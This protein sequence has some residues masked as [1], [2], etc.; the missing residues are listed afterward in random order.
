MPWPTLP[1]TVNSGS[2]SP[3]TILGCST[4][5]VGAGG[6]EGEGGAGGEAGGGLGEG[7]LMVK[8]E[9]WARRFKS[10]GRLER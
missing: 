2:N 1:S 3:A 7:N 6:R 8:L 5:Q 4:P 10:L 9:P